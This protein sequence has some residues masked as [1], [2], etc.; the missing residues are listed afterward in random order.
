M[1]TFSPTSSPTSAPLEHSNRGGSDSDTCDFQ[2]TACMSDDTCAA[3]MAGARL[4]GSCVADAASCAGL[5]DYFCCLAGQGCSDN[6]L[7]LDFLSK[8]SVFPPTS[9]QY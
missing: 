1:M 7:L 8:C 4:D 3:C 6:A 5:S 2:Q 9:G